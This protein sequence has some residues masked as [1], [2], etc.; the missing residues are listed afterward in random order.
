MAE[1]HTPEVEEGFIYLLKR[2]IEW[3]Y[4]YYV[5]RENSFGG[6]WKRVDSIE[7]IPPHAMSSHRTHPVDNEDNLFLYRVY[8]YITALTTKHAEELEKAREEERQRAAGIVESM[9][10]DHEHWRPI[11]Q[12]ILAPTKTDEHDDW[13]EDM[14]RAHV[15]A[16]NQTKV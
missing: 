10:E 1:K 2:R 13:N 7:Q 4:S 5:S 9:M 11:A 6:Y 15:L 3:D 14:E 8:V 16:D 12:R